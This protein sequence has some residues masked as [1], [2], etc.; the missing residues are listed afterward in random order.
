[1]D[2]I[3]VMNTKDD[4]LAFN[5]FCHFVKDKLESLSLSQRAVA[6][7][8]DTNKQ[9]LSRILKLEKLPSLEEVCRILTAIG[10][11]DQI[12]FFIKKLYPQI[13][14]DIYSSLNR[15]PMLQEYVET[16]LESYLVNENYHQILNILTLIENPTIFQIK[17]E[18]GAE[19]LRK[20]KKL[21][22]ESIININ[23]NGDIELCRRGQ[24]S[25]SATKK[26]LAL[27][28]ELYDKNKIG[29]LS[30]ALIFEPSLFTK[31]EIRK[32]HKKLR[33]LTQYIKSLQADANSSS[34]D[35]QPYFTGIIFDSFH[36][37]QVN[38]SDLT[39]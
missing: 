16:D 31:V 25:L 37:P 1:M 14:K 2:N 7:L 24:T 30:N 23:T 27:S 19:G 13:G 35:K 34:N 33:E 26:R 5:D 21:S 3:Q 39:D 4:L 38:I 20:L 10:E 18:F 9:S 11:S 6:K 36:S 15:D 17:E 22:E 32:V 12:S 29:T 28:L 8:S